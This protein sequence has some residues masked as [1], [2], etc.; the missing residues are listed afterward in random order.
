MPAAAV[1][2][3][4]HPGLGRQRLAAHYAVFRHRGGH[5]RRKDC[6]HRAVAADGRGRGRWRGTNR[7]LY[8]PG[9]VLSLAV[10][11]EPAEDKSTMDDK[12]LAKAIERQRR[13]GFG[14]RW[15]GL[16]DWTTEALFAK[17]REWGVATSLGQ[18]P[19]QAKAAGQPAV[20]YE[21]WRDRMQQHADDHNLD[22]RFW[23]DFALIA[24]EEL[25]ERLTPEL[26]CPD[27]ISNYFTDALGKGRK[28]KRHPVAKHPDAKVNALLHLVDYLLQ[29]PAGD[30]TQRFEEVEQTAA[31]DLSACITDAVYQLAKDKPEDAIRVGEILAP[32]CVHVHPE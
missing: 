11:P 21:Q 29:F 7:V 17:L 27:T 16:G 30:R 8:P 5:G 28:R 24:S 4:R 12:E 23:G 31:L 14:F 3:G 26:A 15:D 19:A 18:F 1:R 2:A 20:L 32:S 25:W 13:L 10:V 9:I 6:P 22:L